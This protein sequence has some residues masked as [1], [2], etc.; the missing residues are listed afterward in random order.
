[1][2]RTPKETS[3]SNASIFPAPTFDPKEIVKKAVLDS[4]ALETPPAEAN[5][6]ALEA[7]ERAEKNEIDALFEEW[8]ERFAGL[9]DAR[10]AFENDAPTVLAKWRALLRRHEATVAYT[11]TRKEVAESVFNGRGFKGG[12]NLGGNP[13]FDVALITAAA[14]N[15]TNAWNAFDLLF[16]ELLTAWAIKWA[17]VSM[18]RDRELLKIGDFEYWYE[19]FKTELYL[20]RVAQNYRGDCG[21]RNFLYRPLEQVLTAIAVRVLNLDRR[22]EQESESGE[23]ASSVPSVRRYGFA[24]DGEGEGEIVAPDE[25]GEA[26]EDRALWDRLIRES[27]ERALLG[28]SP[29]K[30]RVFVLCYEAACEKGATRRDVAKKIELSEQRVNA[31]FYGAWDDFRDAFKQYGRELMD[32]LWIRIKEPECVEFSRCLNRI[33][34]T[35]GEFSHC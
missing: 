21:L 23:R 1:M 31:L 33:D 29:L 17:S 34:S 30:R 26:K 20:R 7:R 2:A 12:G 4:S 9:W 15:Q 10:D 22:D 14:R 13:F 25:R 28:M 3:R 35:T 11:K 16:K 27:L 24:P 8:L 32:D 5:R 18:N 19:E 6:E